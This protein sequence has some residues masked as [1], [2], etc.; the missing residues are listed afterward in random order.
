MQCNA[1]A[2]RVL[3]T[4]THDSNG[5]SPAGMRD[6][7]RRNYRAFSTRARRHEETGR[8]IVL[9]GALEK[10]SINNVAQLHN[11]IY[12]VDFF[13]VATTRNNS[14]SNLSPCHMRFRGEQIHVSN[15][16]R[17]S[18]SMLCFIASS[19]KSSQSHNSI[20]FLR[21]IFRL[22]CFSTLKFEHIF[23]MLF[24]FVR[25]RS[26]FYVVPAAGDFASSDCMH[27]S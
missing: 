3:W 6:N 10:Q 12:I 4:T 22:H 9:W 21:S 26:E 20:I 15:P 27:H 2:T 23:N 18:D 11:T 17:R 1:N 14:G 16:R 24:V 13:C 19:I 7:C 25:V 5:G 8:C